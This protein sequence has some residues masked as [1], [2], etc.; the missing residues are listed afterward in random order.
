[1]EAV[2]ISLDGVDMRS[3]CYADALGGKTQ[4]TC[5]LCVVESQ[6]LEASEDDRVCRL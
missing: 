5:L 2:R 4:K 1:L 6:A 3:Q